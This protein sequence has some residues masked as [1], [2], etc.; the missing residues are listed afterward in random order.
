MGVF[1]LP[2]RLHS[3]RLSDTLLFGLVPLGAGLVLR[4]FG[5]PAGSRGEAGVPWTH[6]V[7][8][9]LLWSWPLAWICLIAMAEAML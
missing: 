7:A 5:P 8:V 6:H 1:I 9:G 3:F 2:V 4:L